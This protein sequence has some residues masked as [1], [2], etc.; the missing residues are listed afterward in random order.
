MSIKW[1]Y[2]FDELS[3]GKIRE[4]RIFRGGESLSYIEMLEELR[5]SIDFRTF[6]NSLLNKCPFKAFRWENRLI[7][8]ETKEREY[9]FVLVDS[10]SLERRLDKTS[11][12]EFLKPR[13]DVATFPSL[14]KDATMIIPT[15]PSQCE[16]YGHLASF[17][18]NAPNY[19]TDMLW[20]VVSEEVI[21]RIGR[22]PIWLSTA[23]G[24]VSWLHVRIDTRPKYYQ[25][26]PYKT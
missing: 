25:Y 14:R 24:G 21:K 15:E 19:V 13:D 26:T 10:P 20:K 18:R 16:G 8:T 9:T 17:V 12:K 3:E 11:F 23:G 5:T 2:S 22:E 1:K 6:Y 4:Y 7:T